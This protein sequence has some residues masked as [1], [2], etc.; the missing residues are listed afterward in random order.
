MRIRWWGRPA[1]APPHAASF[2]LTFFLLHLPQVVGSHQGHALRGALGLGHPH[3]QLKILLPLAEGQLL[4]G[5]GG[6]GRAGLQRG[7]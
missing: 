4:R 6:A 5:G 1:P 3:L 7:V 2:Q